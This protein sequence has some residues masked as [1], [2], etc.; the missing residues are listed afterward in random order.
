MLAFL[1]TVIA[2]WA[3]AARRLG[4]VLAILI[5]LGVGAAGWYAATTLKVDTDTSA[6]L[7]PDLDFQ[8]RAGALRE[9][10]PQ[11]KTDMIILAR[12]RSRDEASAYAARITEALGAREDHFEMVFAASQSPYFQQNGLFFLGEDELASRMNDLSGAASLIETLIA[13]PTLGRLFATL[14]ENDALAERSELGGETLDALYTN[15]SRT[16]EAALNGETAPLSWLG[17][18][19]DGDE[20]VF[21]EIIYASPTLDYTRLQ[22]AKGALEAAKQEIAALR[23]E[24]GGRVDAYVTG[25]P[26]LR[27]EELAAV[28]RGIGL[29]MAISLAAVAILLILC[30]R[31]I[32]MAAVTFVSLIATLVLTAAFAAFA[33]GPLNL[34]S[35]AFTVLL[36]G[37]GLDFAIHLLL[38][39]QQ[40]RV[41]GQ[42]KK[43]ALRGAVHEVGP[44]LAIAAPTT[45]LA[46]FSFAPTAFNGM[47]QLGVIAGVGVIIAFLVSITLLP[48]MLAFLPKDAGPPRSGAV[49]RTFD[50]LAAVSTPIAAITIVAGLAALTLTPQVRF[51]ADQMSL[52][53]PR[54]PSV[55]GFNYLFDE[56]NARPIRLTRLASSPQ[57]ARD[58]AARAKEIEEVA[59]ARMIFDFLPDDQEA[60]LDV[61]DIASGSLAFAL[62]AAPREERSITNADGVARLHERLD[63]VYEDGAGARLAGLLREVRA[64]DDA[65]LRERIEDAV[66]AYWPQ[67]V[68]TLRNQLQADIVSLDDIPE[69]LRDRYLSDEGRYRV[70]IIPRGDARDFAALR[71]FVDTVEREIGQVSGGAQQSL[72]AGR[73]IANA[74][75]QA[76]L[77]AFAAVALF[78]FLLI[79]RASTVA[80]ILFP[81]LLAAILTAATGVL[82]NL[83]FNYANVIVLPLLIGIG[84]DSGVHLVLRQDQ[85]AGGETLYGTSTPRAVLFAALTT[86]ASFASLMLS[87]HRGTASMGELLSIAIAWTLV[88]TL[89]VLPAAFRFIERRRPR[90]LGPIEHE[91]HEMK[92]H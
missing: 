38:H 90:T 14:A 66:F 79:R 30:Y 32:A 7:D 21:T 23:G 64:R 44:A 42:D 11:I 76:S 19:N 56:E 25:D 28:Q 52:R 24:F 17:L 63:A 57:E 4:A 62:D 65:A 70:D 71:E 61:I 82:I 35:V 45:A 18:V 75:A 39:V 89:I 41:G 83:P 72:E 16:V 26:A 50:R 37:L 78:L 27:V 12:A 46:F 69:P 55:V 43:R 88:C 6:M 77:I 40:R 48:A 8:R 91:G 86:V 13:E 22:P 84:V 29:S 1:E 2:G 59:G 60:K 58:L 85:I 9:A 49:R 68:A 5:L 33:V 74:M 47:A 81:L 15:L 10:F 53:D 67:F 51:D 31:S 92:T 80:L 20:D 36:I 3:E 73:A 34:V 87:P 54:A